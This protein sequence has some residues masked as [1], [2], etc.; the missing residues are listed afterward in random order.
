[1][2]L[3]PGVEFRDLGPYFYSSLVMLAIRT[4]I[5]SLWS[6][7]L[8][9]FIFT[10]NSRNLEIIDLFQMYSFAKVTVMLGGHNI[11]EVMRTGSLLLIKDQQL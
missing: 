8:C 2:Q 6:S 4:L 7:A 3:K 9:Y 11:F 5:S 1:M 10:L